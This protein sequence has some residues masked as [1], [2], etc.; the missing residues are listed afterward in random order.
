MNWREWLSATDGLQESGK[1]KNN[2]RKK[3]QFSGCNAMQ[4]K[5][6]PMFRKNVLPPSLDQ[7]QARNQQK[8][9]FNG[10]TIAQQERTVK[11][12]PTAM[13]NIRINHSNRK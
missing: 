10:K 4:F 6:S 12:R 11:C 2:N 7:S 8:Q 1:K 13:C 3:I 9:V 5:D